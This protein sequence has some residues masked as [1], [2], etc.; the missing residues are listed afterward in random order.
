VENEYWGDQLLPSLFYRLIA[1]LQLG[2][3]TMKVK[4]LQDNVGEYGRKKGE[5]V[6]V[7]EETAKHWF[8][9]KVAEEVKA[10]K[11]PAP[12]KQKEKETEKEGE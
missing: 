12:K 3:E 5:V 6:E 8:N 2:G 9:L 1:L 10:P 4:T 7:S 11:K